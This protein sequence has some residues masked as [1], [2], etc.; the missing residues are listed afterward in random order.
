MIQSPSIATGNTKHPKLERLERRRLL[1]GN[2]TVTADETMTAHL[3]GDNKDNQIEITAN[4]GVGY[5]VTGLNGTTV[6][7]VHAVSINTQPALKFDVSLGKGKDRVS[8]NGAFGTQD[9]N[10]MTGDGKDIVSLSDGTHFGD[11]NIDTG[12]GD[13]QVILSGIHG[14]KN[15][16]VSTGDGKD[17]V[18][19]TSAIQI[20]G[21][22]VIDGGHGK[23]IVSGSDALNSAAV[24]LQHFDLPKETRAK[25]KHGNKKDD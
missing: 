15:L 5:L 2:V 25:K 9:L 16:N 7:G 12:A 11:I 14:T 3:L 21:N 22:S 4:P 6:N 8:F 19:I 1:S 10:I 20:D 23:N 24:S 18:S 17:K 13:D